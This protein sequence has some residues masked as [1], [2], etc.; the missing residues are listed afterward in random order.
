MATIYNTYTNYVNGTDQPDLIYNYVP[1]YIHGHDGNDQIANAAQVAFING[2]DDNDAVVNYAG[3]S[4]VYLDGGEDSDYVANAGSGTATIYG[5][6]DVEDYTEDNDILVGSP[7]A[8]DVFLV[9]EYCGYDVIQNYDSNDVIFCA[10]TSGYPPQVYVSGYDVVVQGYG[11]TVI[12]QGAAYKQFNFGYINSY[13]G[14]TFDAAQDGD[15]LW[16]NKGIVAG[17]GAED[18][19]VSGFDGQGEMIFGAAQDDTI[20]L[21]DSTLSDIVATSVN[22]NAIAIAFKS[23]ETAVVSTNENLSPTFKLAGGDSYIYN[24]EAGSWQSV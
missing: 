24:R 14:V 23:G 6:Y 10:T 3:Y 12:V 9:G 4:Q 20:N 22:E 11:M 13:G 7:Y 19:F 17:A 21:Y 8:T 1:A 2:D 5:G 16:G 18:I 15:N